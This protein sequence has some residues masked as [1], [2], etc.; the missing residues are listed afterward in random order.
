LSELGDKIEEYYRTTKLIKDLEKAKND[1]REQIIDDI[2]S[3]LDL[4]SLKIVT[5]TKKFLIDSDLTIED[6]FATRFPGYEYSIR[7]WS[8]TD[9]T[10]TYLLKSKEGSWSKDFDRY[11]V[12]K[13]TT[14]YEPQVDWEL[15][16]KLDPELMQ[17]ISK[18]RFVVEIDNDKLS[19]KYEE[20]P[21]IMTEI[22]RYCIQ[23]KP[24]SRIVVT[25]KEKNN[26]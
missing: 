20:D 18:T 19:Q 9:D 1:L 21:S 12:T 26:G 14:Y 6:Y 15:F 16:E 8:N 13:S 5:I 10:E 17:E 24:S 25:A 11:K 7:R 2:E 3:D 23:K 22:E 4:E